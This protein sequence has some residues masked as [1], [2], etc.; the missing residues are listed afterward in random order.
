MAPPTKRRVPIGRVLV[1]AS[2]V[3][4]IA[5]CGTS[6]RTRSR[7]RAT[8]ADIATLFWWMMGVA[9]VGLA[10]VVALLCSPGGAAT[11]ADRRRHQGPK[12]GDARGWYR[13][14]RRGHRAADRAH[15]GALRRRRHLRDQDDA[16]ARS[17]RDEADG[18]VVG[19]QW[20]W[21][22]RYPGT[23][24]VTAN[25]IHIPARTPVRV[26]VHDRRRDPQ[27]LGAAAQPHDRHDP[28]PHERDRARCRRRR[29]VPR[30]VRR[31]L[32]APARP[33]GVLRLRRSAGGVPA[34]ARRPGAPAAA[35][36]G[37]GRRARRAGTS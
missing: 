7:R 35:P 30:P 18:R 27:L 1:A 13:R 37:R 4:V 15:R 16:G 21:E 3:P 34:L 24:A 20:W 31:V 23:T 5:G 33:H 8:A 36:A 22:V 12:P 19:H 29:T 10:L 2:I 32:R 14:R 17:E 6:S 9:W 25:E 26:E 11:G 28:R